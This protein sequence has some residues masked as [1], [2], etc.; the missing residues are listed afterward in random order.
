MVKF[1]TWGDL[2]REHQTVIAAPWWI[3]RRRKP[4][5]QGTMDDVR[6]AFAKAP[7]VA[8][9]PTALPDLDK[10]TMSAAIEKITGRRQREKCVAYVRAALT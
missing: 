8:L 3:N 6:L 2:D 10:R 4:P 5:A 9:H 7:L 1:W